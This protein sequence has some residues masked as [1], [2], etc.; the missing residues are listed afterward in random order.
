MVGLD[1]SLHFQ[2]L[3]NRNY[4]A[5]QLDMLEVKKAEIFIKNYAVV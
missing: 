5:K 4:I 2:A 1:T 3:L